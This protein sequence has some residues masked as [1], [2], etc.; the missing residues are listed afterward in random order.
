MANN[1]PAAPA[2]DADRFSPVFVL[3]TARSYSSVVTTMIGQHPE[4]SGL[5]ELKLFCYPTIGELEASLPEFWSARGIAHR[6]PGLV[7]AIACFEFGSQGTEALLSARSWLGNR[8]HWSGADVLDFLLDRVHPRVAIEKSPENVATD[9]ALL[10]LASAY[11]RARY[12][13]LTRH[14]VTTQRSMLEHL[15]RIAPGRSFPGLPVSVLTSWVEDQTRIMRFGATLPGA[16]Y[17]RVKAEHVLNDPRPHLRSIAS[18]LQ[19][20]GESEAIEAMTHPETSPFASFGPAGSGVVGGHDPGFLRDP[21]LR[22]V[23]VLAT[24]DC[25]PD[26]Q[27]HASLWRTVV[28]V[29]NQL[30]YG[31]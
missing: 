6:S 18:W 29:A 13:H 22:C 11:P 17:L 16:R 8:L 30:G 25:P 20:S 26:C 1:R 27:G 31:I 2:R 4:L 3:A 5:P 19:V 28:V 10:R 9:A 23:P 12:I 15:S 14:P 21:V 24:L 7:R